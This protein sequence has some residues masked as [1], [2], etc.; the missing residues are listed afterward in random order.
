MFFLNKYGYKRKNKYNRLLYI[1][2]KFRKYPSKQQMKY[3]K[4]KN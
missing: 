4:I 2:Y 1:K 3:I